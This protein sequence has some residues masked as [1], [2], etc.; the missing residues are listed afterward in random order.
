MNECAASIRGGATFYVQIRCPPLVSLLPYVGMS[1]VSI[2]FI[3]IGGIGVS[4]LARFY[5]AEGYVVSGSDLARSEITDALKKIGIRVVIG[6]HRASNLPRAVTE[7][8]HTVAARRDNP[9]L[10]EVRRRGLRAKTYAQALGEITRRFRTIAVA[11]AHGKSTTTALCAL[12]LISGG[13]D[14]TVIV[15]AKLKEFGDTNFRLGR[16]ARSLAKGQS[17]Y[18]VIEAD[19]YR[20]SFLNYRPDIAVITNI[21]REHLDFYKNIPN[22]E[23]TFYKFLLNTKP[24]GGAVLNRDDSRLCRIGAQLRRVRP[25]IRIIWFS[26]RDAEAKRIAPRLRI[27]GRHNVSNALAAY[28]VGRALGISVA[29]IMR[30]ISRYHGAWRRFDYQG[31]FPPRGTSGQAGAKVFADYAHH[32]TEIRATLQAA[33]EKFPRSR[34]WCVFQ[35]HHYERTRDLFREFSAAF[36]DADRAVLLDIYEVAGRERRQKVGDIS[37]GKLAQTVSRRGQSAI[38]MPNG[39][40]RSYLRRELKPD[41]ILIMMGAGSIWEMTKALMA[42]RK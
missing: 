18:L 33:R 12:T 31:T 8:V 27:P 29:K 38:Y 6:P 40:L 36:G 39:R 9:E 34:I 28:R 11:G 2:H 22:I 30:A 10:R 16:L 32:P 7:V 17:K 5:R 23:A 42:N 13:L 3:G 4:A 24:G 14:P 19:E 15:G 26:L 35:P 20:A 1:G 21:D 37:S 25:D 41:D